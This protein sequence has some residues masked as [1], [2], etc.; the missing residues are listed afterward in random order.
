LTRRLDQNNPPFGPV[1]F[2]TPTTQSSFFVEYRA[3]VKTYTVRPNIV[4]NSERIT[5]DGR[6]LFR[7]V[8]YFIDYTSGFITFFNE[9]QITETTRIQAT[10]DFSPFGIAGAQQDTLVGARGAVSLSPLSPI[11]ASSLLGATVMYDFAPQQTAAPDIRQTSGS[12]LV[13]ESDMHLKDLIFNPL[14]ML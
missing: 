2:F 4:L 11:L 6:V 3:R 13:E 8:D 10:Y 12:W 9:D 5:M 1:Y 7:S 14:P